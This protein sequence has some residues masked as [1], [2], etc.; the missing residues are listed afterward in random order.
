VLLLGSNNNTLGKSYGQYLIGHSNLSAGYNTFGIGVNNNLGKVS[1]NGMS[2]GFS[3]TN[4]AD[5]NFQFGMNNFMLASTFENFQIGRGNLSSDAFLSYTVGNSNIANFTKNTYSFGQALTQTTSSNNVLIGINVTS[6]ESDRI[7]FGMGNIAMTIQA[8]SVGGSVGIGTSNPLGVGSSRNLEVTGGIRVG[9]LGAATATNLCINGAGDLS[10]CSSS[11]RYKENITDLG[12]GLDTI[13]HLRAVAFD[14][15]D[16]GGHDFGF[17][18]EEVAA[19]NNLLATYNKDGQIQGIKYGQLTAILT[20]AIKEQQGKIDGINTQLAN[21]GL[22]VDNLAA[23]LKNLAERVEADE[24]RIMQ[25]SSEIQ[26]LREQNQLL[27]R[28]VEKLES[29][30]N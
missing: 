9:T 2:L 18:A 4:I 20:N 8:D 3:N 29:N 10:A 24:A 16:G 28:R 19:V 15:K 1:S 11:A 22:R 13:M 5:N 12:L 27:Q 23:E 17:I 14:W 30:S 7:Q 6:A 21:Y 25:N 26:Q